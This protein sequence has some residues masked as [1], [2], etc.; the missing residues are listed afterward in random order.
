VCCAV[1]G[2]AIPWAGSCPAARGR[3]CRWP[4]P[5]CRCRPPVNIS[6]ISNTNSTNS[7]KFYSVY[8]IYYIPVCAPVVQRERGQAVEH[9]VQV[10][11][12]GRL[13]VQHL[14]RQCNAQYNIQYNTASVFVWL[15]AWNNFNPSVWLA[16]HR[17]PHLPEE[18]E[19]R[20]V[21][22]GAQRAQRAG[23]GVGVLQVAQRLGVD[24]QAQVV[25]QLTEEE[26][27][28]EEEEVE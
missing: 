5:S 9:V 4:A 13:D 28:E 21:Q 3:T 18:L 22:E 8:N 14:R 24:V 11:R 6:N 12:D 15:D 20:H 10:V 1:P 7:N 16:S 26:E 25:L 27:E 2:P 17:S 19:R 23:V